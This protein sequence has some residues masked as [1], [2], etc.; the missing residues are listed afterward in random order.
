MMI[1]PHPVIMAAPRQPRRPPRGSTR[2]LRSAPAGDRS[3]GSP[4]SWWA[5]CAPRGVRGAAPDG[6]AR[7][8]VRR[9]GPSPGAR[10]AGGSRAARL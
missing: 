6:D 9:S 7:Q 2:P 8:R 4:I 10:A 5:S 3:A 1:G